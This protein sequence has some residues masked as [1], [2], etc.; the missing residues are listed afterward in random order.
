V[1]LEFS[2]DVSQVELNRLRGNEEGCGHRAVRFALGDELSDLELLGR[3]SF[4]SARLTT[5]RRNAGCSE[6]GPG[7]IGPR[8][9][10]A[11]LEGLER[12]TEMYA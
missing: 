12:R 4:R 2:V 11:A 8:D 9:R 6:L 5:A 1:D 10:A 7:P 3:Q